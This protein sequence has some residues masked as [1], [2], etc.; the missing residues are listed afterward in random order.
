MHGRAAF[1]CLSRILRKRQPIR[2]RDQDHMKFIRRQILVLVQIAGLW[3]LAR[4]VEA[5][6]NI[7]LPMAV[8]QTVAQV[9]SVIA[10]WF[11]GR[12]R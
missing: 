10:L 4:K 6:R 5:R 2:P 8:R 7:S 1:G 12:A 11:G 3:I 9:P